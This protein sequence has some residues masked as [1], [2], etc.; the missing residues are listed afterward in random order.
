MDDLNDLLKALD[1]ILNSLE[2]ESGLSDEPLPVSLCSEITCMG[3]PEDM[4]ALIK[5]GYGF[6]LRAM[7][8][9]A[10][11]GNKKG[12][13]ASKKI[14]MVQLA[15][16]KNG[17][18]MHKEGKCLLWPSML[19]PSMGK[20]HLLRGRR[21]SAKAINFLLHSC[22]MEWFNPDNA[23]DILFCLKSL[24]RIEKDKENNHAN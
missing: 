21:L 6:A 11:A 14:P 16:D 20:I 5:A 19:T 13:I 17:C 2:E 3:T 15:I 8:V 24:E 23:S 22:V 4:S 1:N 9:T 18:V 10:V 7:M 12:V